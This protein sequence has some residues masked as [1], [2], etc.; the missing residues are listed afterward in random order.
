MKAC[1]TLRVLE[2]DGLEVLLS[3]TVEIVVQSHWNHNRVTGAIVPIATPDG[4]KYG[5]LAD[6]LKRAIDSCIGLR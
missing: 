2:I 5:V 3:E 6:Q 4:R 1:V